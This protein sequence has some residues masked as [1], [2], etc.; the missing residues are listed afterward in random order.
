MNRH[1]LLLAVAVWAGFVVLCF[2]GGCGQ[3]GPTE[4]DMAGCAVRGGGPPISN[5]EV[6]DCAADRA[7]IKRWREQA[8]P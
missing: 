1:R 2:L 6:A 4:A 3:S 8:P 7:E 5:R